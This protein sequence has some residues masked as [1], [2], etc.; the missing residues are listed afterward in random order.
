MRG[1]REITLQSA[2]RLSS[3]RSIGS[4]GV[5]V[6][7][8]GGVV[9]VAVGRRSGLTSSKTGSG[10]ARLRRGFCRNIPTGQREGR[11]LR[12]RCWGERSVKMIKSGGEG[13]RG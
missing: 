1:T 13:G 3:R 6:G 10:R 7:G 8:G 4:D 2:A 12:N 9:V 11:A 5:V